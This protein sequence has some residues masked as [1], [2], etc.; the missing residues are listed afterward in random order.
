MDQ[1]ALAGGIGLAFKIFGRTPF[2]RS[3]QVDLHSDLEF[4]EALSEYYQR[5]RDEEPVTVKDKIMARLF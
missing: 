3:D 4:F 1:I 2:H 5:Q